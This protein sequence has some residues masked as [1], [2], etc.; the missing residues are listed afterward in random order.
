[1]GVHRNIT[2]YILQERITNCNFV[3]RDKTKE[4]IEHI[5]VKDCICGNTFS[6]TSGTFSLLIELIN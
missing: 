6:Y 2:F 5:N 4:K 1:M 3:L